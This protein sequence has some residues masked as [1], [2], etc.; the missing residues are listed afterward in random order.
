[1]YVGPMTELILKKYKL[2]DTIEQYQNKVRENPKN[3][4]KKI[5]KVLKK[6]KNLYFL[7]QQ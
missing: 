5:F 7:E 3:V 1:M 6:K 2:Y 4:M